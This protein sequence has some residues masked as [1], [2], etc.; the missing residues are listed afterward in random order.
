MNK[1]Q[2]AA[3]LLSCY[4]N[5]SHFFL[6]NFFRRFAKMHIIILEKKLSFSRMLEKYVSINLRS[7][8]VLMHC[9]FRVL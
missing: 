9:Y 7:L 6:H 2:E 1:R 8:Y 3:F 4:L 5:N